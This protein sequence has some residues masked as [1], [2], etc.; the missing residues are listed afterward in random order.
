MMPDGG[1]DLTDCGDG[2]RA[3]DPDAHRTLD[4]LYRRRLTGYCRSR[5]D[6]GDEAED[7]VQ[8]T[9]LA[10][11]DGV[12]G[13]RD[14]NSLTGWLFG[15]AR[16]KIAERNRRHRV[17]LHRLV[18]PSVLDTEPEY[19]FDEGADTELRVGK[20]ELLPIV[21]VAIRSLSPQLRSVLT[22]V[23]WSPDIRRSE[24]ARLIQRGSDLLT[25]GTVRITHLPGVATTIRFTGDNP[26]TASAVAVTMV[27]VTAGVILA[28]TRIRG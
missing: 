2:L 13:L 3:G 15:I 19:L 4:R 18:D 7:C 21:A 16:H 1:I 17:A 8:D 25:T 26:R 14:A 27:A 6:N 9:L 10:A 23:I 12:G 22:E 20:R 28:L 5:L 11:L 24:L